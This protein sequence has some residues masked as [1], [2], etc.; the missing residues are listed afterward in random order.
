MKRRF[1]NKRR[2]KDIK[3]L[4][5]NEKLIVLL[6]AFLTG[7]VSGALLIK[8]NQ[9]DLTEIIKNMTGSYVKS[10]NSQSILAGFVSY[11]IPDT[12]CCL[13]SCVFGLSLIGEPIIWLIPLT[14][15][16][17]IGLVAGSLYSSFSVKGML[18]SVLFLF[19]PSCISSAAMIICCKENILTTRQIRINLKTNQNGIDLN[20]KIYA[21]RNIILFIIILLSGASGSAL[22]FLMS[23]KI[24]LPY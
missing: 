6:F 8:S 10:L 18:F 2:I 24:S 5:A 20:Y 23:E 7:L 4:K 15:G 1:K 16:L 3:V 9:P 14:R 13:V 22:C 17:G 12:V 21:I 19:I 11:I